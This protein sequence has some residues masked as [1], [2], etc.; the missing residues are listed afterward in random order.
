[1]KTFFSSPLRFSGS[2]LALFLVLCAASG[3]VHADGVTDLGEGL[4]YLRIHTIAASTPDLTAA[5]RER[6]SLVLDFR[7]TEITPESVAALRLAFDART[8]KQPILVLVGPATPTAVN[9]ILKSTARKCVT[10]GIKESANLPQVV[11]DQSAASDQLAYEALESGQPVMALISGKIN[12]ERFDEAALMKE[13]NDG[14]IDAAPPNS[15]DPILHPA[16]P[17]KPQAAI[18]ASPLKTDQRNSVAATA[19]SSAPAESLTDRVLQRA[20]HLHRA[21]AAIKRRPAK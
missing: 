15:P 18:T 7:H 13:F 3:N 16:H 14:N 21:V 6:D 10:L 4:S 1:M 2:C 17:D 5:I 19:I 9:D 8:S 20:V 12:K 11:V